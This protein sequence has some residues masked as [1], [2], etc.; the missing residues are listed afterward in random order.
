[1]PTLIK[2][3]VLIEKKVLTQKCVCQPAASTLGTSLCTEHPGPAG[4]S[5]QCEWHAWRCF[6][7]SV[8]QIWVW[9]PMILRSNIEPQHMRQNEC[10]QQLSLTHVYTLNCVN[11]HIAWD[12][13][14]GHSKLKSCLVLP[15]TDI[16]GSIDVAAT[17][18]WLLTSSMEA[19]C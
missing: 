3:P 11:L 17:S 14:S 10:H 8:H 9:K 2:F 15:K 1:M 4:V 19:M 18:L 13:A 12:F 6:A 7:M 5:L 16:L